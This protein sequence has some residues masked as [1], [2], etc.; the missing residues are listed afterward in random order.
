MNLES[1]YNQINDAT[2]REIP[3]ERL[4]ELIVS[5]CQSTPD[6]I[7]SLDDQREI[8]Y[9][10]FDQ[11]SDQ[12]AA[13]LS[14][15]GIGRGDLVGLCCERDAQTP[16]W[17][18]GIL[19]TGAGYVPLDP[20]YPVD[21]L[22]YMVEDSGLKHIVTHE[23]LTE[24]TAGFSV[25]STA[26]DRDWE[27]VSACKS[28]TQATSKPTD[29]QSDVAYV[30][31]TS[32]STGKPKG[33]LVTHRN[34]VNFLSSM[35]EWPGFRADERLLAT[36][37]LSFDISVVEIFLP[38]VAGGSV[39][40]V[41]R[42]TAKDSNAL[43]AAMQRFQVNAMQAT[44]AMWRMILEADFTGDSQ[45]KFFSAGEP[46]PRDLIK[47]L[48]SRCAELWNVYGPTET[49]VY[50]TQAKITTDEGRILVG[51]PYIN[52]Q[53]YVV[54]ENDELCPPETEGELLIGGDGVTLGYLNRPE[55]NAQAFVQWKGKRVYR[56][57]DLVKMTEDGQVEHL[58][59]MDN[60][61]KFNAH[62]IELGE[63]DAAMAMCPGVRRAATVL[64]EDRPGDK[65]LVG[66]LIADEGVT[67]NLAEVRSEIAKKLP[68]YM[69]PGIIT[70]VD[71]FQYTPSGKLDRKSFAPPSTER[72]D[73]G[74]D[75]VAPKSEP[76]KQLSSLWQDVLQLD[77]VG[78]TDNFFEFG[79]NSI[80]AMRLIATI[81]EQ[82]GIE[83]SGPEFFDNPTIE[84]LLNLSEKKRRI[85]E[86][87]GSQ[88]QGKLGSGEY[89][90]VGMAA[91]MPGAEDLNRY[92]NNLVEG[93]ESI[94]FFSPEELDA[95]LDKSITGLPN[96]VAA[97]GIIDDADHFDAKF[98][99]TPPKT[100]EM[101][102]PQQ[103]ILLELAWTALE[104]AGII[105]SKD[106]NQIGIWAG[107]YTTSY[108]HKNV[109]TNPDRVE[110]TGE[111]QAGV[112][113]EKD[114]IATRVAHALNLK[115]PAINVNTA[116]STSLVALIEACKSL[117]FGHCDVALAG[118][119]SV[120][121]PQNLSLIH[122]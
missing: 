51:R 84:A 31:Y 94:K 112:L 62:R 33:V 16:V 87:L 11:E 3:S 7:A 85:V 118:A 39:A 109:L 52:T 35:L 20:D 70:V 42:E 41:S 53:L 8:T 65:Q 29:P 101:T 21:R 110:Q 119:A 2:V 108:F 12:L 76:Q 88:T 102:C 27:K 38:L 97:R 19:K 25:P 73:I 46:L 90:I 58:G 121:F 37:T 67:P 86:S 17:L 113:N 98:F 69:V 15:K 18:V 1:F 63:I 13:W 4:H 48:V 14:S 100:A 106:T 122:I 5:V 99:R 115:G 89:A 61:I 36:T 9:R 43:V 91:R 105:P 116:C 59:R 92:W 117:D 44:P 22:A 57:G 111:F 40:V 24:L 68:E 23:S 30:I 50:S 66:Y 64:R 60:Q 78:I 49:T 95:T 56:T 77:R 71:E 47:P 32:G 107:T 114:Y 74:V 28:N 93:V 80:R 45:M 96:Y 120:T 104:D 103:R 10:Q 75:Y 26:I 55:K 72:P 82:L 34:V 79:G 83:V 54:D 81:K 6:A